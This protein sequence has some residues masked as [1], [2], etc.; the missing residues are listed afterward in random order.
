MHA[1]GWKA[2]GLEGGGSWTEKDRVGLKRRASSWSQTLE[3]ET[4]AQPLASEVSDFTFAAHWVE[5][6]PFPG[7]CFS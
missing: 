7:G 3:G 2:G 1:I 5:L 4:P 6:N